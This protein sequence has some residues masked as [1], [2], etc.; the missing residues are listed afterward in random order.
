MSV[1]SILLSKTYN[2]LQD[3]QQK[4][5]SSITVTQEMLCDVSE[6]MLWKFDQISNALQITTVLVNS[7]AVEIHE[8]STGVNNLEKTMK[9]FSQD[10]STMHICLSTNYLAIIDEV[11][12]KIKRWLSPLEPQKRHLDILSKWLKGIGEWFI[13]SEGFQSWY[14]SKGHDLSRIFACYGMPDAGKSVIR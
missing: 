9:G 3:T 10:E 13:A 7:S 6:A 1:E 11:I 8:I 12:S 2:Q 14:S 5:Q 4:I